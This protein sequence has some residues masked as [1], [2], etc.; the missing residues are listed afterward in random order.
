MNGTCI[1]HPASCLTLESLSSNKMIDEIVIL[2]VKG[3]GWESR[4]PYLHTSPFKHRNIMYGTQTFQLPTNCNS[5]YKST[6]LHRN[7]KL[8]HPSIYRL[9]SSLHLYQDH[10]QEGNH[11]CRYRHPPPYLPFSQLSPLLRSLSVQRLGQELA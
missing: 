7:S 9:W 10:R 5:T 2:R 11:H 8:L 3:K 6:N 4:K 1:I